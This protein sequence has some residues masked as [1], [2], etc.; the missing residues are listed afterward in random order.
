[1]ISIVTIQQV[2]KTPPKQRNI[3]IP[4]TTLKKRSN[5]PSKEKKLNNLNTKTTRFKTRLEKRRSQKKKDVKPFN[6]KQKCQ[7]DVLNIQLN[8]ICKEISKRCSIRN[9]WRRWVDKLMNRVC[10]GKSRW[11]GIRWNMSIS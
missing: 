6:T 2:S 4:L 7:K 3:W 1:M 11:G 8:L 9:R 10:S 5:S